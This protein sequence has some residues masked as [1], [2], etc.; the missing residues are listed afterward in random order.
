MEPSLT[1]GLLP[2]ATIVDP[3]ALPRA[4]ELHT[5]GVRTWIGFNSGSCYSLF[6][7][8]GSF[9]VLISFD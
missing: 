3:V 6:V 7:P 4:I 2:R 1:V 8:L 5:F 9:S